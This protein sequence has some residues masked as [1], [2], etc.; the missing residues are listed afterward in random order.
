MYTKPAFISVFSGFLSSQNRQKWMNSRIK[1]W[2]FEN[3]KTSSLCLEISE[4]IMRWLEDHSETI[5]KHEER[6]MMNM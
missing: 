4:L 2:T 6:R 5:K 3:Q 1:I